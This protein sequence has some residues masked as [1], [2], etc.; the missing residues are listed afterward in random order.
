MLPIEPRLKPLGATIIHYADSETK[1]KFTRCHSFS[2]YVPYFLS[3]SEPNEPIDC[4]GPPATPP[5]NCSNRGGATPETDVGETSPRPPVWPDTDEEGD[6]PCPR[7]DQASSE[8]GESEGKSRLNSQASIWPNGQAL[9]GE[10]TETYDAGYVSF[11]AWGQEASYWEMQWP[12]RQP[13]GEKVIEGFGRALR[14]AITEAAGTGTAGSGTCFH[15]TETV[16]IEEYI[17][18]LYRNAGCRSVCFVYAFV[19]IC[20][21]SELNAGKVEL[22]PKTCHKLLLAAITIA[23]KM[24]QPNNFDA[25]VYAAAGNVTVQEL[26]TLEAQLTELLQWNLDVCAKSFKRIFRLLSQAAC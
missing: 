14:K 23:A 13:I 24:Q 10:T 26:E 21:M 18:H 19:Y 25:S 7:S 12:E 5:S 3:D 9:W 8:S 15:G 11:G 4:A 16:D 6:G 2:G 17:W 22:S 20:R 1:A